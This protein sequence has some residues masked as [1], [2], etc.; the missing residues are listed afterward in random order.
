M[1]LPTGFLA[2]RERFLSRLPERLDR[3]RAHLSDFEGGDPAALA[4]LRREAHSLVGAAGL[5][6]MT[7]LASGAAR[8]E[9]LTNLNATAATLAESIV[10][11]AAA[12]ERQQSGNAPDAETDHTQ[13]DIALLF[14]GRDEMASQAALLAGAGY[15]VS[16]YDSIEAFVAAVEAGER[17]DLL[18][19]G[20][21]FQGDD[22]AGVQYLSHLRA[23]LSFPLPVLILSASRSIDLGMAAYR[24]GAARVL[25]KPISAETLLHCVTD[26]L[27][28]RRIPARSLLAIGRPDGGLARFIASLD[29]SWLAVTFC[30]EAADIPARLA[31]TAFD[32]VILDAA[33]NAPE[34]MRALV[35]L[36]NDHPE[37]AP[38][39]IL[40]FTATADT[41]RRAEAWAA[42]SAAIVDASLA[43]A[44]FGPMLQALCRRAARGRRNAGAAARQQ[45]E[46]ARQRQALDHHAIISLAD[47]SGTVF[48]TSPRHGPLTGFARTELIGS[49]LTLHRDGFAPPEFSAETLA[50]VHDGLVWQ[51][52]YPLPCRHEEARWVQSS[53][54]P[55]LDP[56][57]RPYQYM[58]I[59]SDITDRKHGEQALDTA[60]SRETA[61]AAQIQATLLL[62]ALPGVVAGVP[63]ASRSCASAGVAG[64]FHALIELGPDTFDLMIGDV[65]GKGVPAAL[66]GAAVKM[67]LSQCLLELHARSAGAA[68]PEPSAIL[69]AL[70]RRLTSR[71]IEL[72]CFVTLTYAR[73]DCRQQTLTSLGCGHPEILVFVDGGVHEV[74]NQHPPLGTIANEVYTQTTTPWPKGSVVLLYSDGLSESSDPEGRML[75]LSGLQEIAACALSQHHHPAQIAAFVLDATDRF[76]AGQPPADDRTLIAVRHATD[77]EHF[78]DLPNTLDSIPALQAFILEA[79]PPTLSEAD[80]DRMALAGVE[81]FSNIV[82]H[83][84]S[85]S[86]TIGIVFRHAEGQAELSLHYDGEPFELPPPGT[87]PEPEELRESGYGLPLIHALSDAF[88]SRHA[89]GTNITRL[90]F[91]FP[92]GG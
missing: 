66:V 38:L 43:P 64:D 88:S 8:V 86:N 70:H 30:T 45:Y 32:A 29:E 23:R 76:A 83:A 73:F 90:V 33:A 34:R 17:P 22:Y 19:L 78:G 52:E 11:I 2:L 26:T 46:H 54:V 6:D 9:A 71:L 25:A 4:E 1:T 21:Q 35:S 74:P 67:E 24:A 50:Q 44:E 63:I 48:E 69:D 57:G 79:S 42:G 82:K 40:V 89:L 28:A 18:L 60:R 62:P 65:M 81:A 15:R 16:Q 56:Q 53:L 39:P 49:H 72:E 85:N 47:A 13:A 68:V 84:R 77:S 3:M 55:F 27:A 36:L 61:L 31:T 12:I 91:H 87:L 41:Q 75:D 5:H 14:Q 58:V 59:R 7:E 20:L 51:G 92:A 80:R 10:Q 37:S